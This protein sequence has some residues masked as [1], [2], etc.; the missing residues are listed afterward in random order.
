MTI[1]KIIKGPN[2]FG[3]YWWVIAEC[4]GIKQHMPFRTE[5][6]ARAVAPGQDSVTI[7]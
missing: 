3:G 6:Q 4:S 1:T 5:Q 2:R 7:H